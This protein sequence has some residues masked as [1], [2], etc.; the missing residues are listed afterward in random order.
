M[1]LSQLLVL[2]LI[3]ILAGIGIFALVMIVDA[4]MPKLVRRARLNIEQR[5]G[6]VAI[7]GLVNL[8]F[9]AL[10]TLA[11]FSIAQ[12]A[13]AEGDA[14]A[15][16]IFRIVGLCV[17]LVL[18]SFVAVGVAPVAR[19]V[20]ERTSPSELAPRLKTSFGV[21]LLEFAALVPLVGWIVLPVVVGILGYGAV[22]MALIWRKD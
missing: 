12:S 9:F 15:A 4:L 21:M 18:M 6:R 5:P 16:G 1:D 14:S 3:L 13:E 17:G 2:F 19:L 11:L 8:I 20:G 10:V 22:I 7:V